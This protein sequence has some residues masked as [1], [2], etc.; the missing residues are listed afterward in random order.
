MGVFVEVVLLQGFE[1]LAGS[2]LS[3]GLVEDAPLVGFLQ[4]TTFSFSNHLAICMRVRIL[5][6]FLHQSFSVADLIHQI[7]NPASENINNFTSHKQ[8]GFVQV[9]DD[10]LFTQSQSFVEMQKKLFHSRVAGDERPFHNIHHCTD[11]IAF[12]L[13]LEVCIDEF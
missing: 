7:V 9:L 4:P 1:R 10:E 2:P 5:I 3:G 11:V 8:V 12:Q 6:N 13:K